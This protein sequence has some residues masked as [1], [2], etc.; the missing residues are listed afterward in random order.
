MRQAV[1]PSIGVKASGGVRTL[2]SAREMLDHWA[3]SRARFVKV[4]PTEYRRAL[5]E[6]HAR[7]EAGAT[8]ARAKTGKDAVVVPAK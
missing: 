8:I 2:E 1:G 4:F 7:N 6:M 5:G 3:D